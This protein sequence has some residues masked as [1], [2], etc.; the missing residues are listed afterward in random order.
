MAIREDLESHGV[1]VYVSREED[2]FV[3]LIERSKMSNNTDAVCFIS[4]HYNASNGNYGLIIAN[5]KEGSLQ[6]ANDVKNQL[7]KVRDNIKIW[8]NNDKYSV[9]RNTN[10]PAIIVETCFMDNEKDLLVANTKEKRINIG[11]HI[12]H[13]I[14]DYLNVEHIDCGKDKTKINNIS[15]DGKSNSIILMQEILQNNNDSKEKRM[16]YIKTILANNSRIN[17]II[18]IKQ[19]LGID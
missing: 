2:E 3:E 8:E 17:F 12:S 14:L 5:K 13:G 4:V 19:I 18:K 10:V 16:S 1:N 15:K 11:K 6:L 9:L 7:A